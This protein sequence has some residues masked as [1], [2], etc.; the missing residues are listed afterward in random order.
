MAKG[1]MPVVA[2]IGIG[3]AAYQ[4]IKPNNAVARVVKQR[5]ERMKEERELFP[6][7]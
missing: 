4:M 2:S 5:M 7:S 6:N 3:A 1:W